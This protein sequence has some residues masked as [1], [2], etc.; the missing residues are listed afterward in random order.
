MVEMATGRPPFVE[1]GSPQAAMFKVGMFKTHPPIPDGLSE[2]CKRFISRYAKIFFTCV[3]IRVVDLGRPK[4]SLKNGMA[5]FMHC[6]T[7]GL[8]A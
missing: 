1:L 5:N 3:N 8:I 2:R 7:F 6:A 4:K